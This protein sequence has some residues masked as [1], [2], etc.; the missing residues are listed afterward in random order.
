MTG[1]PAM[2]GHNPAAPRNQRNLRCAAWTHGR[3]R[4]F[5]SSGWLWLN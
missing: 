4:G 2:Q 1:R 3:I 5:G